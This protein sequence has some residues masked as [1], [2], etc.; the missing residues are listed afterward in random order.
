MRK[1]I[2]KEDLNNIEFLKMPAMVI[3]D[4]RYKGIRAEGKLLYGVLLNL[5]SLSIKKNWLNKNGEPFVKLSRNKMKELLNIKGSAKISEVV[6]ELREYGLIEEKGAKINGCNEIYLYV[7][8]HFN[9]DFKFT[10]ERKV[11]NDESLIDD[12]ICCTNTYLDEEKPLDDNSE[13][14]CDFEY[15]SIDKGI[16]S[17]KIKVPKMRKSKLPTFENQS[18]IKNNSIKNN[19]IKDNYEEQSYNVKNSKSLEHRA[20]KIEPKEN[21]D[22]TLPLK[23]ET[24]ELHKSTLPTKVEAMKFNACPSE[25]NTTSITHTNESLENDF[26]ENINFKEFCE[27]KYKDILGDK[28]KETNEYKEDKITKN[29]I[30]KIDDSDLMENLITSREKA[31]DNNKR[32]DFKELF[33]KQAASV[34]K[35]KIF[36]FEKT[37]SETIKEIYKNYTLTENEVQCLLKASNNNLYLIDL[38]YEQTIPNIK[39]IRNF[40]AYNIAVIKKIR[41]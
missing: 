33:K 36:G 38:A 13:L 22:N 15:I 39:K 6:K 8:D 2:N 24:M 20:L 35:G 9:N 37:E 26:S 23:T 14:P 4:H 30:H 29:H 1:V 12:E 5:L 16:A 10:D 34:E 32:K 11:P 19:F 27:E 3:Y 41:D 18:Y 28:S 17:L 7:E 25:V 21:I 40:V 31:T